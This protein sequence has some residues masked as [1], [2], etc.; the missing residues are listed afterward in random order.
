MVSNIKQCVNGF[1][2]AIKSWQPENYCVGK[3]IQN[4][5]VKTLCKFLDK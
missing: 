4:V 3:H 2:K 5:R 1:K